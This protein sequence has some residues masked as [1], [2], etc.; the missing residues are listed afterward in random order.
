MAGVRNRFVL[1]RAA[2][3]DILENNLLSLHERR[4]SFARSLVYA[5]WSDTSDKQLLAESAFILKLLQ[6]GPFALFA[7]RRPLGTLCRRHLDH[8]WLMAPSGSIFQ[9]FLQRQSIL[10][11]PFRTVMSPQIPSIPV[12]HQGSWGI[13]A[14]P[15]PKS[16]H[17]N[18]FFSKV[19]RVR[20]W[21]RGL[22]QRPRARLEWSA[23]R[24]QRTG[25][26]YPRRPMSACA[27]A[28]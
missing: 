19:G 1:I 10:T 8:T 11:Q 25:S 14:L 18:H 20:P 15:G 23:R 4:Q 9:F 22:T 27:S 16:G 7:F 24:P 6:R 3:I 28:P 5:L 21:A 26:F 12:R 2:A 13:Q 17:G